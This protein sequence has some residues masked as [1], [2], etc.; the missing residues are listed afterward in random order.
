MSFFLLAINLLVFAFNQYNQ[1]KHLKYTQMQLLLQKESDSIQYYE[2]LLSQ[3]ENQSILIHDIKKHLQSIDILNAEKEHDKIAIYIHQL[4]QSSDL[5]ESPRLCDHDMLNAILSRYQRQCQ[6]KQIAFYADIRSRIVDFI[7]AADL[8]SLFC[9]L[10]DNAVEAAENIPDA[11]IA[12]HREKT[13]FVVITVVN[14]SRKNPLSGSGRKPA[15]SKPDKCKHGFGI[16]SIHKIVLK[17]QGEIQMYY[18]G[19][20]LTFHTIITLKQ[21]SSAFPGYHPSGYLSERCMAQ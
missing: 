12:C 18:D 10:L 7:T 3:H 9:N 20:S 4:M 14:S 2:M 8:T 6:Q 13:P 19:E 11:Y 17:Y 21:P 5:K 1:E 16:K 15:T